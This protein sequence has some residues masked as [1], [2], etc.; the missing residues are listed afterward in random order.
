[1]FLPPHRYRCLYNMSRLTFFLPLINL[2]GTMIYAKY[3]LV[4]LAPRLHH[5]WLLDIDLLLRSGRIYC[6]A[7][8]LRF[9][10]SCDPVVQGARQPDSNFAGFFCYELG[11][12]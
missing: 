7:L 10:I 6:L 3:S 12:P 1:M 9:P 5:G 4:P 2:E 8:A 11:A